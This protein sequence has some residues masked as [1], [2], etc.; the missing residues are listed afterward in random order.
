MESFGVLALAGM[1]LIP[2]LGLAVI[3]VAVWYGVRAAHR[4]PL[5]P[6]SPT[7][8]WDA[9]KLDALKKMAH[10]GYGLHALALVVPVTAIAALILAYLKRSEALGSWLESHFTWQIRTFWFALLWSAIGMATFF[11][12]IGWLIFLATGIWFIY[13]VVRGWVSLHDGRPLPMKA[14]ER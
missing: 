12:L 6:V 13:R 7:E 3:A 10:I 11:V 4:A 1:V 14:K 9:Q 8:G 5:L 2:L